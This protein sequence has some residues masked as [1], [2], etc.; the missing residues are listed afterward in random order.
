LHP[1]GESAPTSVHQVIGVVGDTRGTTFDGSDALQIYLPLSDERPLDRPFL[2]RVKSAPAAVAA[3][4]NAAIAGTDPDL[5]ATISV[6]ADILHLSP[7]VF[8]SGVSAVVASSVGVIGLLLALMGIHGTVSHIVVLRTREVGI[9]LAIGAQHRDILS[10]VVRESF[11]PV[12]R[13]LVVGVSAAVLLSYALRSLLFGLGLADAGMFAIVS[14]LF[15]L[16]AFV[17]AYMPSRR[18]LRVDPVVALRAE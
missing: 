3:D 18:A 1:V 8:V 14:T 7:P 17:A 13:G 11:R 2:V 15:L 12:I 4:I 5:V 9:R 6:I 10:L 16:I